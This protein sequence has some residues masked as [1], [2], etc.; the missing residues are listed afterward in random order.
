MRARNQYYKVDA[1]PLCIDPGMGGV[2]VKLIGHVGRHHQALH[3]IVLTC[4]GFER[5]LISRRKGHACAAL[6]Q[7]FSKRLADTTARAEH[8]D[9]LTAPVADAIIQ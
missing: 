3:W 9:T 5:F 6:E 2:D 1:G 7:G 8:P 4:Q